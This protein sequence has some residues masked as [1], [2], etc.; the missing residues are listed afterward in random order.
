MT[1]YLVATKALRAD[2]DCKACEAPECW[3]NLA[4]PGQSSKA[5]KLAMP[6][7]FHEPCKTPPTGAARWMTSQPV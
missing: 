6:G 3:G 1:D 4:H 5:G 2:E 7:K